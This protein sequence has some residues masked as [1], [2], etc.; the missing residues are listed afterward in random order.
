MKRS[1][2]YLTRTMKHAKALQARYDALGASRT[3]AIR[4]PMPMHALV[5][6][7]LPKSKAVQANPVTLTPFAR[8]MLGPKVVAAI[9]RYNA[10]VSNTP[11]R[12]T[13]LTVNQVVEELEAKGY[14]VN[15]QHVAQSLSNAKHDP[16]SAVGSVQAPYNGQGRRFL[17]FLRS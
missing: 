2:N 6:T 12:L 14:I 16:F 3:Q 1:Q 7:V 9:E 13:G 5:Q 8:Q 10:K 15:R 4:N 17:Y 11:S